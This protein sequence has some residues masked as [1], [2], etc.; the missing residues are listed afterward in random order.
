MKSGKCWC[1]ECRLHMTEGLQY[2]DNGIQ[3]WIAGIQTSTGIT[4]KSVEWVS[5]CCRHLFLLIIHSTSD[6][7]FRNLSTTSWVA[8]NMVSTSYINAYTRRSKLRFPCLKM[9]VIILM[10]VKSAE[11]HVLFANSLSISCFISVLII[12][13]MKTNHFSEKRILRLGSRCTKYA[14]ISCSAVSNKSKVLQTQTKFL[15]QSTDVCA[16]SDS[17]DSDPATDFRKIT[18]E[19]RETSFCVVSGLGRHTE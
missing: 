16:R 12:C 15:Y 5:R 13:E 7:D 8:P 19:E 14:C 11:K 1:L 18:R 2:Y 4:I 3:C 9:R 10:R 6:A 17:A